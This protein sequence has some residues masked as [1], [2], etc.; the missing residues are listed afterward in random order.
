AFG[1]EIPDTLTEK[2]LPDVET[3]A[4]YAPYIKAAFDSKII[5]GFANGIEPNASASRGLAATILAK[6]AGFTDVQDNF[7][8]NYLSHP[9]WTYA[10]FP[11]VAMAA[12][13]AP[14][15]AY[16]YD[17]GVISGYENGT[18]G[19]GNPI[20]RAEIAKIVV[21]LLE[22]YASAASEEP[23]VEES[24]EPAEESASLDEEMMEGQGL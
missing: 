7:Q 18:F 12:Y 21:N 6:A 9:N 22:M 3:D 8:K 4:W 24:A 2:P 15:V 11:D 5:Y 16:L 14:F 19:P 20:T 23:A 13:Y 10:H 17:K 1:F